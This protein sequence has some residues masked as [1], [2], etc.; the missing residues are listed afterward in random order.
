MSRPPEDRLR[1]GEFAPPDDGRATGERIVRGRASRETR[2]GPDPEARRLAERRGRAAERFAALSLVLTGWRIVARNHG[3][4]TGRG[5]RV[6]EADLIARRGDLVAVIEVKAR[7]SLEAAHDAVG[8]GAWRRI[9]AAGDDWLMRRADAARLSVRY[10]LVWV[11][12]PIRPWRWP[13]RVAG[14]WAP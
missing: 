7:P 1:A 2:T 9:E 11:P 6:G 14:A 10:D 13:V 4:G 8:E 12:V 3:G 5:G